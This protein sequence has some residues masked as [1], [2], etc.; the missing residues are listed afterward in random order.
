MNNVPD[1]GY[2]AEACIIMEINSKLNYIK[3]LEIF[4]PQGVNQ[5]TPMSKTIM[6]G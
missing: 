4:Y 6:T 5:S 2:D 1:H 3:T